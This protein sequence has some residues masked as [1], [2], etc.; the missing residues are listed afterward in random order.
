MNKKLV[1]GLIM[2][3]AVLSGCASDANSADPTGSPAVTEATAQVTATPASS[4]TPTEVPKAESQEPSAAETLA[5][6]YILTYVNNSDLEAKKQFV[7]EHLHPDVQALFASDQLTETE[8]ELKVRHP[9]VIESVNYTDKDGN[10]TEAVLLQGE[11]RYRLYNEVIVLIADGKVTWATET[12]RGGEFNNIRSEF[13]TPIPPETTPPLTV[14]DDMVNFVIVDVWNYGF[15][16]FHYYALDG[17]NAVGEKMEIQA[18]M[19]RLAKTMTQKQEYDSYIGELDA[20][21]DEV[22]RLWAPLSAETDRLYT[23]LRNNPPKP[24]DPNTDFDTEPFRMHR[25]NFQ[26]VIDD[27]LLENQ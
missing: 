9:R 25:D 26:K 4:P 11:T 8:P 17:T 10:Q 1:L 21:Y 5:L 18:T 23:Q 22:K 6:N 2:T 13:Q 27:M 12:P 24:K 7:S 16:E 14:L 3:G 19:D 20:E 15:A